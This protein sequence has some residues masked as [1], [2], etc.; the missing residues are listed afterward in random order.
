MKT[1]SQIH[2]SAIVSP[3][4]TLGDGVKIGPFTIIEDDVE[5][6]EGTEVF[7]H[8]VIGDGARIGKNCRIYSGAV[9][10]TAPQD[11]K[12]A[13]EKTYLFVGDRTVVREY[14]TLNRG[15]N[16]HG[17]TVIGSDCFFLAYV[18]IGHDCEVGNNVIISNAAQIGGHSEIGN[19]VTIGGI[20]GIHQFVRIGSHSMVGAVSKVAHDVPPYLLVTEDR[21]EGLNTIGLKRRGFSDAS[22]KT[23]KETYRIVFQSGLLIKNALEKVKSEIE[24]TPEVAEVLRFFESGGKRKYIR[25]F[26]AHKS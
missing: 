22:I 6:G 25:P 14:V 10:S 2:P 7:A 26:L 5:I 16:A 17:K 12:Y 13:G 20:A 8:A 1:S 21:F 24:P 18:H 4:A 23:L 11:V 9:L 19:F 3:K 15:T